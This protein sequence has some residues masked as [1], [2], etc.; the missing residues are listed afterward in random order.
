[1]PART[2]S[3]GSL[4]GGTLYS[5]GVQLIGRMIGGYAHIIFLAGMKDAGAEF[6]EA[7]IILRSLYLVDKFAVV[8]WDHIGLAGVVLAHLKDIHV[9]RNVAVGDIE[10]EVDQLA[11]AAP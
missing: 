8:V 9:E 1:M 5:I 3:C 2:A 4:L 7:G 10:H 6:V 11:A